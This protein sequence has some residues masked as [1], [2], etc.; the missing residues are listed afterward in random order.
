MRQPAGW[1]A[2]L[3]IGAVLV[4]LACVLVF[5]RLLHPPLSASELQGVASADRRVE[6]QQAQAKLQNDARATL[7][8]GV[9][10]LLLVAGVIATW[11]QVQVSREGQIT[12]RFTR[13]VE[14]LGSDKLEVRLGGIFA[15]ERIA[16]DSE[17]DRWAIA[18]TLVAFVRTHAPWRAGAPESQ[19]PHP[20][21]TIDERLPWLAERALD[22]QEAVRVLGRRPP[23]REQRQ[24]QLTRVDLRRSWLAGARLANTTLR[25]T[26]LAKSRLAE[27]H[28]EDSDL[29]RADLRRV[30]AAGTHFSRSSLRS[31]YLDEA[32]L[33]GARLDQ[34]NLFGASLWKADLRDAD[35]REAN[36][37]DADLRGADL[38]GADLERATLTGV[39]DDN[40]TIWPDSFAPH[41]AERAAVSSEEPPDRATPASG[42][43]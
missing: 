10:G 17:A 41:Q 16:K 14:Q 7:L 43:D 21:P 5:P 9:A 37:R 22:V 30:D 35:L 36:L 29:V 8:Q 12:E 23:T 11:R 40:T 33:H 2:T 15:L 19:D 25:N 4:L 1:L 13:A 31:A 24:L 39:R 18:D 34:A 20:T 38:R 28:L 3:V 32:D 27:A 6:L 26:N 42:R